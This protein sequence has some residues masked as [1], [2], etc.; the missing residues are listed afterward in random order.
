MTLTVLGAGFAVALGAT[1]QRI[2]GMGM[3]LI[4]APV[5]SILLGPVDGV[6][7]VNITAVMNAAVNCWG[8]RADIDWAKFAPIA[9]ALIVGVIPAAWVIPRVSTDI[10]LILVGVLL[11]IALSVVTL[12]KRYLPRIEGVLP[13]ATAGAIG[14]FMNTL[15]GV[16]GPAIT[17]YAQAARW[18]QR[19]YAATLQP[20]FLCAGT[21]SFFGKQLAGAADVTAIAPAF[22]ASIGV[23]LGMGIAAGATLAPRV[24]LAQARR[25]ALS[26]AFLGGATALVRG[27]LGLV[28]VG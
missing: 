7:L 5:L 11:L 19:M 28:V 13:A 25:I 12:G 3:G 16:A 23:G 27:L 2:S 1:L 9:G 10:L 17:V 22:W 14:G 6:L 18:D 15:S 21:L 8:L 24:P 20:I 26:L 4:A